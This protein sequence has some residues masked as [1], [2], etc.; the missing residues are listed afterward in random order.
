M[1]VD[2][3][4]LFGIDLIA[5]GVVFGTGERGCEGCWGWHVFQLNARLLTALA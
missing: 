2:G 3:L 4:G 1:I 5:V